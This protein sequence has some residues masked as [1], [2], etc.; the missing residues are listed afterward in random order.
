MSIDLIYKLEELAPVTAVAGNIDSLELHDKFG[1]KKILTLGNFKFG[2]FH[3]HGKKGKTVERAA[4][5]F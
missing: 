3:G 2:I 1:D 4:E 5:C